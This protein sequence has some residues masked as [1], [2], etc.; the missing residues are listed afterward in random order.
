VR[1]SASVHR[2]RWKNVFR[3]KVSSLSLS[4][5]LFSSL[6]LAVRLSLSS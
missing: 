3:R 5:S 2:K 4:P 6:S 1:Q